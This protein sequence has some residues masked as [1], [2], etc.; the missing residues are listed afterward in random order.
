MTTYTTG[1]EAIAPIIAR[2][3]L[4]NPTSGSG[5]EREQKRHA[6]AA[7][8]ASIAAAVSAFYESRKGRTE[9]LYTAPPAPAGEVERLRGTLEPVLSFLDELAKNAE[10]GRRKALNPVLIGGSA[11]LYA[12]GVRA[13]LNGGRE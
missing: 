8:Y 13:A 7:E 5:I 3:M 6:I 1:A 10:P 2:A 12:E 4:D 9:P 11:K